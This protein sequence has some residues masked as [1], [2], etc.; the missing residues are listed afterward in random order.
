MKNIATTAIATSQG[1]GATA[2]GR[3]GGGIFPTRLRHP[4][5]RLTS[6]DQPPRRARRGRRQSGAGLSYGMGPRFGRSRRPWRRSNGQGGGGR[7]HVPHHPNGV[8]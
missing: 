7:R 4:D 1:K 8:P 5:P 2:Q 6:T 3:G